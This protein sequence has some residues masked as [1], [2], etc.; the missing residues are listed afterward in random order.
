MMD[1]APLAFTRA[2][3]GGFIPLP[4]IPVDDRGWRY[5]MAFFESLA[6]RHGRVEFLETHLERLRQAAAGSG[7]RL[8]DGF[9]DG[10]REH[11]LTAFG[12]GPVFA[13]L[14]LSAGSGGPLAPVDRPRLF[15]FGEPREAAAPAPY[16]LVSGRTPY[17]PLPGGFK[18]ANYWANV[19]ALA[20]ARAAGADEALLFAPSGEPVSAAMANLFL[21]TGDELRTPPLSSGARRGVIREWV[22]RSGARQPVSERPLSRDDLRTARAAF[23]TSSWAGIIPVAAIDGQPL[24]EPLW[25][26]PIRTRFL[27]AHG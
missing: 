3:G 11:L 21:L 8:E 26:E 1:A 19:R 23:L 17:Q 20:E 9:F 18:T 27:S 15:A 2:E 22:M 10:T 16:R 7:W 14:Y 12:P 6:I 5:G 24:A 25:S 13:R 4:G